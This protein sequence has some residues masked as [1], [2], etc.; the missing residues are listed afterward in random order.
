MKA[1]AF[2]CPLFFSGIFCF[3]GFAV[4]MRF[5]KSDGKM[6]KFS[7]SLKKPGGMQK[8]LGKNKFLNISLFKK[9]FVHNKMS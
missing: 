4:F 8:K 1:V 3:H 5:F 7:S 6:R 2:L 9:I